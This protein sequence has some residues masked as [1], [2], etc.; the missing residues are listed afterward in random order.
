[1]ARKTRDLAALLA[2][3]SGYDPRVPLSI[4]QDPAG[5][6]APL[7]RDVTGL[8]IGWLGDLGGHLPMEDGVLALCREALKAFEGLGAVVEDAASASIPRRSGRAGSNCGPSRPAGTS[9]ALC[10]PGQAFPAQAG[11]AVRGRAGP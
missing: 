7:E 5:F 1:M 4:Q 6:L 9:P 2:V 8:R 3:Q 10:R 11:G